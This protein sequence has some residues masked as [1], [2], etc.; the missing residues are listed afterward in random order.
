MKKTSDVAL[1]NDA[2]TPVQN[3]RISNYVPIN[4]SNQNSYLNIQVKSSQS[5]E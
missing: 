5:F 3:S 2:K 4:N 1:H